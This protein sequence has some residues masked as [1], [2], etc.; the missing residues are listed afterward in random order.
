MASRRSKAGRLLTLHQV[1]VFF[2][3]GIVAVALSG[4]QSTVAGN[5]KR[6][7]FRAASAQRAMDARPR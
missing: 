7:R 1:L 5:L 6:L 2:E 4:P 3:A